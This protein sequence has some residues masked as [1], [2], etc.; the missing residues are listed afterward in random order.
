MTAKLCV[1][2]A[3]LA[4]IARTRVAVLPGWV[5]PL[6]VLLVAALVIAC[7]TVL[8]W[9]TLTVLRPQAI[10]GGDAAAPEPAGG[11]S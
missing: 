5:V 10:P 3:A 11:G 7:V 2:A 6:P 8:A 1:L 9:L 4:V